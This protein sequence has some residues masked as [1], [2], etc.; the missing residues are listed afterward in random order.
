MLILLCHPE[1]EMQAQGLWLGDA[2]SPL[3]QTGREV[4]E[5]FAANSRIQAD[6]AYGAPCRQ[7]EEFAQYA[8]NIPVEPILAF[9]DRS[10]GTLTGRGY[11]E[12]LA[13]F[14]RRNWLGWQ[15]SY[16][17]AP[18]EGESLFD[19]S[20]RVLGAFWNQILP[21]KSTE[22]VCVIGAPDVLR[23]IIGHLSQTAITE[24]SKINIETAVPYVIN[25]DLILPH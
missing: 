2:V 11:R 20:D 1:T 12:T 9:L 5:E 7:I 4:A 23:I 24:V 8:L 19:I 25:G 17:T 22:T 6:R 13:E 3:S 21:I 16:W 10:M 18:P 14:P 15:R